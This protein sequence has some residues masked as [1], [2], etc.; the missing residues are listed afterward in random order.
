M[1]VVT[2]SDSVRKSL[3]DSGSAGSVLNC[4]G[5]DQIS[6][7]KTGVEIW[8]TPDPV[9]FSGAANENQQSKCVVRVRE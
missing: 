7:S 8:G 2:S 1:I 6:S 4:R 3:S 5:D 9:P